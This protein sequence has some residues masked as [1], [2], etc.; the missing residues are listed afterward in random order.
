MDKHA[1]LIPLCRLFLVILVIAASAGCEPTEDEAITLMQLPNPASSDNCP[2]P[3]SPPPDF[4][5]LFREGVV[6]ATG[7]SDDVSDIAAHVQAAIPPNIL[8]ALSTEDELQLAFL[9]SGC[10]ELPQSHPGSPIV[11]RL[12]EVEKTCN[13][14]Y[15]KDVL[16]GDDLTQWHGPAQAVV[17]VELAI[18]YLF[19]KLGAEDEVFAD[20]SYQNNLG[21]KPWTAIGSPWAAESSAYTGSS[22]ASDF[23]AQKAFLPSGIGLKKR[24]EERI[25]PLDGYRVRIGVFDTSPNQTS[26]AVG[27]SLNLEFWPPPQQPQPAHSEPWV[28]QGMTQKDAANH[29]LFVA[30]LIREI[31]PK[32]TIQLCRVLNQ[33]GYGDLYTLDLALHTFI[34]DTLAVR[35]EEKLAGAV[36]NLSL[37][38]TSPQNLL[39][40][41][42]KTENGEGL[43]DF[44]L[45]PDFVALLPNDVFSLRTLL[46]AAHCHDMVIVAAS[47]NDS[48]RPATVVEWT[49]PAAWS[50]TLAVGA[51]DLQGN[52]SCFTNPADV[53]APG[54]CGA[55]GNAHCQPY[56]DQCASSNTCSDY[57]LLGPVVQTSGSLG[58]AYW[59]GTSFSAPLVSG[60]AALLVQEQEPWGTGHRPSAED[61]M[62]RIWGS[63]R[64][65]PP[66]PTPTQAPAGT[67]GTAPLE[68][69]E[70]DLSIYW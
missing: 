69:G 20:L 23:A 35:E 52:R 27:G 42:V 11:I 29:G 14:V 58:Y 5:P 18:V 65:L 33:F 70:I 32:S 66:A 54:G 51:T 24:T 30:G 40:R 38:T 34:S 45:E 47:G 22:A 46:G 53:Y 12:L 31:A 13:Y 9:P 25:T 44:G 55:P 19:H 4:Q 39:A 43:E 37:A 59:A 41:N 6:I 64:S 50:S 8:G 68:A 15:V 36:I 16:V 2:M 28:L 1:R 26:A 56:L 17:P 48:K 62:E 49:I 60:F 67:A 61:I 7:E 21:G 63:A 3:A 10:D 57:G